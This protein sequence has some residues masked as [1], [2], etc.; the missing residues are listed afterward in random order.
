MLE[1]TT[2]YS[3][4]ETSTTDTNCRQSGVGLILSII[5]HVQY[6]AGSIDRSQWIAENHCE[7]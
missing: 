7:D 3:S 4:S 5:I 6:A 1:E 2:A